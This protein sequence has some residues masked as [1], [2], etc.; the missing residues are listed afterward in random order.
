MPGVVR[1]SDPKAN[2]E[3]DLLGELVLDTQDKLTLSDP[4]GGHDR[5]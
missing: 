4:D 3:G 2:V 1:F 5:W